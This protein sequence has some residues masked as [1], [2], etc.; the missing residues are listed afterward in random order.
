MKISASFLGTKNIAKTLMDLNITDV[1]YIHVDIM[2][3]KYVKNKTISFH[4][5]SNITYYTRKRL[6]VHLMVLNPLKVIDSYA[7]LNVE[8]L[9]FHINIQDNLEH[10]FK[11]CRDYG[12]KIGLAINPDDDVSIVYP[13]LDKI[14]LVLLMSVNPGLPGQEFIKETIK[15][16]KPL[17]EEINKRNV[18]VLL[19]MDGGI[20]LDNVKEIQDIDILVSGSTITNSSN[21]QETINKLRSSK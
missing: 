16:I 8:Y 21:F 13:Y 12:I 4:E 6:D 3:G 5:L 17:K 7:T 19:S 20:T 18:N 9:T 1:D 11:R 14:D 15:K 10:I 2:D